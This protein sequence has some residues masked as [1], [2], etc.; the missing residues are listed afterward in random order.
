MHGRRLTPVLLLAAIFVPSTLAFSLPA[1]ITSITVEGNSQVSTREIL[2]W[3][4]SRP[5]LAM[6][7]EV[8]E[9]DL[10]VI[11]EGYQRLGYL[12]AKADSVNVLYSSDSSEVRLVLYVA[13]GKQTVVGS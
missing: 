2:D 12:T 9:R 4:S 1:T 11:Q 6:S 13:E 3:L 10:R 7:K 5:S 8:L